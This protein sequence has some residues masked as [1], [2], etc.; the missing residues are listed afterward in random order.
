MAGT[1]A[2]LLRIGAAGGWH[3]RGGRLRPLF[4][5]TPAPSAGGELDDLLFGGADALAVPGLGAGHMPDC[6]QVACELLPG[7]RLL[8]LA[9]AAHARLSPALLAQALAA[10]TPE[11]AELRLAQALGPI[12]SRPWPLAVIEVQP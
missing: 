5:A 4:S 7:D 10:A 2:G 12:P 6:E 8:L 3:A 11:D 9:G 1:Q